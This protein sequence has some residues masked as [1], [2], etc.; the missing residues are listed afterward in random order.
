LAGYTTNSALNFLNGVTNHGTKIFSVAREMQLQ[1]MMEYFL[2]F[3]HL[4]LTVPSGKRYPHYDSVSQPVSRN[5]NS[6]TNITVSWL[7]GLVDINVY[8]VDVAF[9][10]RRE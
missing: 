2:S 1:T 10:F 8:E 4:Q 3:R 6:H 7:Y 9:F 5:I